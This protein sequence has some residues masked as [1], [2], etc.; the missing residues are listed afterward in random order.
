MRRRMTLS[1]RRA[2]LFLR[3]PPEPAWFRPAVY[4]AGMVLGLGTGLG[5]GFWIVSSGTVDQMRT[6]VVTRTL[7]LTG[8]AGLVVHKVYAEGRTHTDP[9]DLN[10][11]LGVALGQP[12]LAVDTA[13]AKVRIEQLPWVD[14]ASVRRMLPETIQV[15][16]RE[17][18]PL[19]LWQRAGSLVLIDRTGAVIDAPVSAADGWMGPDRL[20]VLVGPE[21]PRHAAQLFIQL[22]IEPDL[23]ERVIAATRV[24][25]RRWTIHL[26]NQID[27]LLPEGDFLLAWR[28][29]ARKA[30]EEA[31]LDRAISMI[32]LRLFP[33]R[34]LL[35]LDRLEDQNA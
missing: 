19:A 32:D 17:R 15:H 1:A 6:S 2:R 5:A 21:A 8:E 11:Q 23:W 16:L 25:D 18:Q 4:L 26:D 31:L 35:R 9:D 22:S 29:L 24:G 10:R 14:Q 27:V 12:L 3:R 30:R 13:A 7:D 28:L 20:R 33:D 34:M